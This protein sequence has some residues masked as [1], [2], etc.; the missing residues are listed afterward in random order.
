[1]KY[2]NLYKTIALIMC[3][4][5]LVV[6]ARADNEGPLS[7]PSPTSAPEDPKKRCENETGSAAA[8]CSGNLRVDYAVPSYRSLGVDRPLRFIYSSMAADVRPIIPFDAQ[9]RDSNPISISARLFFNGVLQKNEVFYQPSA[10]PFRGALQADANGLPTGIYPY[11]LSLSNNYTMGKPLNSGLASKVAVNNQGG[12]PFGAGWTLD[13]LQRLV[14]NPTRDRNTALLLEGDGSAKVFSLA[15]VISPPPLFDTLK[16]IDLQGRQVSVASGDFNGD[17]IQDLAVANYNDNNVSIFLG[18][19]DG[20]FR[21][22]VNYGVGTQPRSVVAARLG[23]L[24]NYL[25]LAVVNEGSNHVSILLGNGDG[26]FRQAQNYGVGTTPKAIAVGQFR[27]GAN[28]LD[29]AV[30]NYGSNNVSILLGNP[31]G[32][33]QPSQPL[34]TGGTRPRSIAAGV[35]NAEGKLDL[36]VGHDSYPTS[37]VQIL[38]GAGNGTFTLGQTISLGEGSL[39][40]VSIVVGDFNG[41]TIQDLGV[42]YVLLAMAEN[43]NRCKFFK[44][45]GNRTF[46]TTDADVLILNA[47]FEVPELGDARLLLGDFNGDQLLDLAVLADNILVW[48]GNGD[49]TFST[50]VI[51]GAAFPKAGVIA[52]FNGD[53]NL[54]IAMV[55]G[56][57]GYYQYVGAVS[58]LVGKGDGTFS[59]TGFQTGN[60]PYSMAVGDFNGDGNPDLAVVN[61][62]SNSVSIALGNGDGTFQMVQTLLGGSNP[63]RVAVGDFNNDGIDDLVVTNRNTNYVTVQLGNGDGTFQSPR[64]FATGMGPLG[65]VVGDFNLDGKQD[66]AVTNWGDGD[67][68][69]TVSVLINNTPS[70][71]P[72]SF[73]P[74]QTL[75]VGT[76]PNPIVLGDF[77]GDGCPDLAVGNQ[78]S[79]TVSILLNNSPTPGSCAGAFTAG[80]PIT[81][82]GTL[83]SLA[84]GDFN[85]DGRRD[86]AVGFYE[87]NQLVIL[88]GNGNGTFANGSSISMPGGPWSVTVSDFN[89]DG[90]EDLV[91]ANQYSHAI[92]ILLGNGDP[93]GT[94]Q[95]AQNF[96]VGNSPRPLVVGDFN[97]DGKPDIAVGNN[98]SFTIS[99]LLSPRRSPLGDDSTL[100]QNPAVVCSD[101]P[102]PPYAY[103]R[104]MKDGTR[105]HFDTDGLHVSTVDRNCNITR[106]A[107]EAGGNRRLL[108]ITDPL[109]LVT[110]FDY[111]APGLRITDPAGRPTEFT[112]IGGRLTQIKDPTLAITAF[113]YDASSRMT[114]QTNARNF[115]TKYDY[116]LQSGRFIQST[117]PFPTTPDTITRLVSP[118][119]LYGLVG[120]CSCT[121]CSDS[122]GTSANLVPA[123]LTAGVFGQFTDGRNNATTYNPGRFG[124][125]D[126]VT[127]ALNRTSTIARDGNGNPRRIFSANGALVFNSFDIRSNL[128]ENSVSPDNVQDYITKYTYHP[129]FNQV[130]S[131]TDPKNYTTRYDYD[132]VVNCYSP[133]FPTPPGRGN[134]CRVTDALGNKTE[135]TYNSRGQVLTIINKDAAGTP[136]ATTNYT[137]NARGNLQ[138]V[139]DPLNRPTTFSYL[140]DDG[141]EDL[142]GNI[143]RVTDA[144]SRETRHSYD[145]MN[146]LTKVCDATNPTCLAQQTGITQYFYRPL[147]LNCNPVVGTSATDLIFGIKDANNTDA[148]N[149]CTRLDYDGLNRLKT[150]TNPLGNQRAYEYDKAGNLTQATN[151][152]GQ[153]I[154]YTYDA[155]NQLTSKNVAGSRLT[156]YSYDLVGNLTSVKSKV[157]TTCTDP[158]ATFE[159][160]VSFESDLINRR[161]RAQTL[162]STSGQPVTDIRYSYD[163]NGNRETMTDPQTGITI[164]TFDEINRLSSVKNPLNQI[165]N[166]LYDVTN[167]RE[168]VTYLVP[169]ITR[170]LTYD[171]AN[172]FSSLVYTRGLTNLLALNYPEYDLVGNRLTIT[173]QHGGDPVGTNRYTYDNLY[174]ELTGTHPQPPAESV[175]YDG[176]GNR[177]TS[178]L[179][180]GTSCFDAANRLLYDNTYG[181]TYDAD[182]NQR[183][184]CVPTS[185][186]APCPATWQPP[187]MTGTT[188]S[189]NFDNENRLTQVTLTDGTT[190]TYKYDGLGRRIEKNE[191]G[192]ITRYV[193][194]NDNVLETFDATPNWQ[195]RFTRGLGPDDLISLDQRV[196][197]ASYFYVVDGLGSVM[198]L[199]DVMGTVQ[200]TYGYDSFGN[201]APG[202]IN[203]NQPFTYTG[204]EWDA[205]SGLHYYRARYYD[206]VI[207]R[208]ISEDPI[209]FEGGINFYAYVL[210][211]PLSFGDAL[212]LKP[213][214]L[215]PGER[216]TI[217]DIIDRLNRCPKFKHVGEDLQRMLD[218]GKIQVDP[219]LP[220]E[221]FG[222]IPRGLRRLYDPTISLGLLG[223]NPET[224]IHE[225]VH[226]TQYRFNPALWLS[227][228]NALEG[229]LN[230][231]GQ[232]FMD[233]QADA[234]AQKICKECP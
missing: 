99:M 45:T 80:T 187:C 23:S 107:Y 92:S 101:A 117:V 191:R 180:P 84:V 87:G 12:S 53:G 116:D 71:G 226:T 231:T 128:I 176:V 17:A 114:Q 157:S 188:I 229:L 29:L 126:D 134:L 9:R 54:D 163:P 93:L 51:P 19:G 79:G 221:V 32:T 56:D 59:A 211:N 60:N 215:I 57:T 166:F 147:D 142:T 22:P 204:R 72:L 139:R 36:A 223:G 182:G 208:F 3:V 165:T 28:P 103:R 146:R 233:R 172:Q 125:A 82:G 110:R 145:A 69:T 16:N 131:V 75:T 91:V 183:T 234:V 122:C 177:L 2:N 219:D 127:D 70:G 214:P 31:D 30:A 196:P 24:D 158:N 212:G 98:G 25:D 120:P 48:L 194:D 6:S 136:L 156:C 173:E 201:V 111:V 205:V 186:P 74:A 11:T 218:S 81:V 34:A 206:P 65:V 90:K 228:I 115:T 197:S 40:P 95:P 175:T 96:P 41:D 76:K 137:Y 224:L 105:I 171:A 168:T 132:D 152:R 151:A 52:D 97:F 164:Y 78:A 153:T 217:Q 43:V 160:G 185:F 14:R 200:Q 161:T 124:A 58:L 66:L 220:L 89:A 55:T 179:R 155:A 123:L 8:I 181:Y 199:A 213:R 119:A 135:Y 148:S 33:F 37:T 94:F 83:Y 63:G 190:V 159:S 184:R 202:P 20:T 216:K 112:I 209:G 222:E 64:T 46:S 47:G 38:N 195:Q 138:T 170:V 7:N 77:N 62:G 88:L 21:A 232:G 68:G 18:N 129:V 73:L 225:W 13:G 106:Y 169:N 100:E 108:S 67:V 35:F 227:L 154:T 189:Y 109:E 230:G 143:R 130:A 102:T 1:M 39:N 174:R 207:G 167:R 61:R 4:T 150:V 5:G 149:K 144:G 44:G 162:S 193:Y 118:G 113:Q 26:T 121:P 140:N 210:N 85:R 104:T 27:I 15:P 10:S 133:P 178:L 49:G 192:T 86:L 198:K 42:L 50:T 141:T 203:V